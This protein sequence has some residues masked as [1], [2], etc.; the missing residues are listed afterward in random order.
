[1]HPLTGDNNVV[2]GIGF[3]GGL[4]WRTNPTAPV[5]GGH[6]TNADLQPVASAIQKGD[7]QEAAKLLKTLMTEKQ[8]LKDV[9]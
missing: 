3:P 4:R 2:I 9:C 1:M 7:V 5:Q 6:E 8:L